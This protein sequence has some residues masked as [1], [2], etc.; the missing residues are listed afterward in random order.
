MKKDCGHCQSNY[1]GSCK[2]SDVA[3][4]IRHGR[5]TKFVPMGSYDPLADPKT[6]PECGWKTEVKGHDP[7]YNNGL[8]R[9]R[10]CSNPDCFWAKPTIERIIL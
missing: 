8:K 2:P 3:D 5:P 10:Y 7:T 1:N 6:C 4:C 9:Y